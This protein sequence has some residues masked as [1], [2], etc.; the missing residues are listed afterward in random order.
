MFSIF[1]KV[2]HKLV[3]FSV[4]LFYYMCFSFHL[5]KSKGREHMIENICKIKVLNTGENSLNI[6]FIKYPN[7]INI[8]KNVFAIVSMYHPV[9]FYLQLLRL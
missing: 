5:F 7:N 6:G 1:C 9:F 2:S 8:I 3:W 4:S